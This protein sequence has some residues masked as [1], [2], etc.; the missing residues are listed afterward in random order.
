MSDVDTPFPSASIPP[1][2]HCVRVRAVNTSTRMVC[3]AR[4]FVRPVMKNHA[5][6]NFPTLCFLLERMTADGPRYVLYDLGS[7]KDFWNGSPISKSMIGN[8]VLGLEVEKGVD[9]ILTDQGIE[10]DKLGMSIQI[11]IF[12]NLITSKFLPPMFPDFIP[13][14]YPQMQ[15]YGV[16][17]T[18]IIL[19][20][21]PN[22]LDLLIWS[23]GRVLRK[24]SCL[25][26]QR[27]PTRQFW[28]KILRRF[29]F[30]SR[31][32]SVADDVRLD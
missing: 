7:R 18:G 17:G 12:P 4:A 16:I 6:L 9:E 25:A 1:S 11:N 24:I 31:T 22:S 15:L 13:T 32:C 20:I 23:L 5:K 3:D 26:G 2:D 21:P 19:E 14:D 29:I 8:H 10:L 30:P 27:T 28:P